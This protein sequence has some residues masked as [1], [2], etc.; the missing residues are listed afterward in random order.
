M[1]K[2]QTS[3]YIQ[4]GITTVLTLSLITGFFMGLITTEAFLAI[5]GPIV[6]YF[7]SERKQTK[8]LEALAASRIEV[9]E[10]DNEKKV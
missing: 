7:F 5:V 6:G 9:V 1:D 4:L 3:T 8:A 2:D 10:L